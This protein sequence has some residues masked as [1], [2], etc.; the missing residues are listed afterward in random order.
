MLGSNAVEFQ[1]TPK[2]TWYNAALLVTPDGVWI[3]ADHVLGEGRHQV[4][5]YWHLAP[6]SPPD[7]LASTAS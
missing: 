3:V 4:D 5:A 7:R 2:E 1:A 6:G